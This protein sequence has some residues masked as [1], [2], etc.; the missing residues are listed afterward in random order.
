MYGAAMCNQ[1]NDAELS[2]ACN[3]K[4][5]KLMGQSDSVSDGPSPNDHG[6]EERL[7]S[8]V[9]NTHTNQLMT[10]LSKI[11][12]QG[13]EPTFH[14]V[15]S[16]SFEIL[17]AFVRDMTEDLVK[18][19]KKAEDQL[20]N[21]LLNVD[22]QPTDDSG[23]R[24]E[25]VQYVL[26]CLQLL[27][28][29]AQIYVEERLHNIKFRDNTDKLQEEEAALQELL[30]QL[31]AG[32]SGTS[33]GGNDDESSKPTTSPGSDIEHS[34]EEIWWDTVENLGHKEVQDGRIEEDSSDS[35]QEMEVEQVEEEENSGTLSWMHTFL[36][37]LTVWKT[38]YNI[39]DN[40]M[41]GLLCVIG[42]ILN[43]LGCLL[44]IEVI[45]NLA[46]MFPR[47][48]YML[49]KK[50]S[51]QRDDFTRYVV[52]PTCDSVYTVDEATKVVRNGRGKVVKRKSQ[53]CSFVEFPRH[54]HRNFRRPCGTLLM[55]T[56]V[57]KNGVEYVRPKRTFCYRSI[58]DSLSDL[59]KRPGF[60]KKCEEWR[61]RNVPEGVFGDIYDGNVWK[62]FQHYDGKPFLSEPY[63]LGFMMNVDWFQPYDKVKDSIGVIY[64]VVMNLPR[65]ERFKK[66]NIIVVGIIPGPKEPKMHINSF[67]KPLV[68]ELEELW[69]GVFLHDTSAIGLNMYRGALLCLSSDIPATRKTGGFLG[70]MAKKGC[71]KCLKSFFRTRENT[72]DYSG[73]DVDD[74]E[75]RT[76]DLHKEYAQRAKLAKNNAERERLEGLFGARHSSLHDLPY[77]DAVRM[78]VVDPMHNILE[79]TAKRM[80]QVWK[81]KKILSPAAFKVI[82]ARVDGMK[83]P[84]DLDSGLPHKIEA[85]FEGFTASQWK[86]WVCTYS[87]FALKGVLGETD[88][89]IWKCF[90]AAA[91]VL[92]SRIITARQ[93]EDA[94][95]CLKIFCNSF[96]RQYGKKWCTM[97]LH[98]HLHLKQCV[99]DYGPVH[100]FWCFAFERANG[101]LG[102]Y[103]NNNKDA[104]IIMMRK[105]LFNWQVFSQLSS[106]MTQNDVPP[107]LFPSKP[108]R[109]DH[110]LT[111]DQIQITKRLAERNDLLADFSYND[112]ETI[113][114]PVKSC[115][116]TYDD[117]RELL[118]MFK[119]LYSHN[120]VNRVSLMCK[121]FDRCSV[122]GDLLSSENYRTD[123]A[124]CVYAKW[125]KSQ[126]R[127]GNPMIDPTA[128]ARPG[129]IVRMLTVSVYL[130]DNDHEKKVQHTVAEVKWFMEHGDRYHYG[131][132]DM[133][134]LWDVSFED[135][136]PASF[137]PLTR[138][139]SRCAYSKSKVQLPPTREET[140]YTI[141]P[142]L[143]VRC[144]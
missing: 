14:N 40:A 57:G 120:I 58:I 96:E 125:F 27:D 28:K 68:K 37:Y 15:G 127:T 101:T 42:F 55:K 139:L 141:V 103:H 34:D 83:I 143:S 97:N 8:D 98:L 69:E 22:A 44:N 87:L 3:A 102:D 13:M 91:R 23:R 128:D 46:T 108:S 41:V 99:E 104:E 121:Q 25:A 136:S 93:L 77:F 100:S 70:H 7:P 50:L 16:E 84:S 132:K 9:D 142:L 51:V 85:S 11:P 56:V 118:A 137:L 18:G 26:Q 78:H 4:K 94:H 17:E 59:V 35:E 36:L 48:M 114:P 52:C 126:E 116:M 19:Y 38:N 95:Q 54:S 60:L 72:V 67:L 43:M 47:T 115:S 117:N 45:K 5:Q 80:M 133:C 82:Q 89:N 81:E 106:A 49:R 144:F 86:L 21:L 33:H 62:D 32:L 65:E 138:V 109:A 12:V 20:T 61:G 24:G 90:V 107:E 124:S 6:T 74:W 66:E 130:N 135:S 112:C 122:G 129:L 134:S 29:H 105:W 92:C 10:E 63:N 73:F 79:G 140:V 88:Y 131:R 123:K 71:S 2:G 30:S 1:G 64:L 39:S 111:L 75:P 31:K 119:T 110:V 113:L 53:K 76:N